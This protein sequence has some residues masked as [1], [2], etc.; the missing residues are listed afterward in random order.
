MALAWGAGPPLVLSQRAEPRT[1]NPVFAFDAPTRDLL[2]L[3]HGR[4]VRINGATLGTEASLA[5]SWKFTPDGRRCIVEL[6]RGVKFSDGA[7][8]DADDV[9]FTFAVYQDEK[10]GSAQRDLLAPNGLPVRLTKLGS[11]R[12]QLDFAE[13]HAPGERLF[14]GL[15]ILPRHRLEAAW[16]EGRLAG[17][18]SI[19][20]PPDQMAG[21]G[22]FVLA[23]YRPGQF[24][25]LRRNPHY[26]QSGKPYLDEVRIV[27]AADQTAEA[28]R[29]RRG[30]I[31][32]LQRPP[33]AVFDALG[34]G[35]ARLDAGASLEYQF[36]FFNLNTD[37]APEAVRAKQP[38]FRET[39]FRRAIS[40]AADRA[41][42]CRLAFAGRAT[43]LAHHVTPGNRAWVVPGAPP[44]Q[45]PAGARALLAQAGFRLD[46]GT[47]RDAQGRAVEFNLAVNAA[48]TAH[49]QLA[50]ILQ[51]DLR[52]LGISLRIVPLEFRSL[53]DRVLK[54]LD[55]DAALMALGS[56]DADPNAEMNVWLADGSMHVWNL[57][58]AKS[59]LPWELEIDR[60]M[61]QQR[62]TRD[63]AR[64]RDLYGQVQR[65]VAGHLPVIALVSP[66]LL[67]AHQA[68][69]RGVRPGLTPPYALWNIEDFTWGPS[70]R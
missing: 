65:L 17:A 48:N 63:P 28:L 45:D 15:A 2:R 42:M 20:T 57:D 52:A 12:L 8:F 19:Q 6:R 53:V 40:L 59:P 46:A 67:V 13:P 33:A 29:F 43:P 69:L 11:H 31:H 32:L 14:D 36:V 55:Y 27:V 18:W 37:R 7:P 58:A 24:V 23:E 22:P 56:G 70:G 49:Q 3:L 68:G 25:R 21:L 34:E 54:S 64:R 26:W 60:L 10:V 35:V 30:E 5:Q 50:T 44:R 9:V 62:V 66:H 47:L 51:A 16:R 1:F 61:K 41:A 38:W 4:L 39:A